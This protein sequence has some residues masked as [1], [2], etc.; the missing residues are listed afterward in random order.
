MHETTSANSQTVSCFCHHTRVNTLA[1][2]W[3]I[4]LFFSRL[5]FAHLCVLFRVLVCSYACL[6]VDEEMMAKVQRAMALLAFRPN[7]TCQPYRV[8]PRGIVGSLSTCI[9]FVAA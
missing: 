6:R 5:S 4:I 3:H 1:Y 7:T 9:W 8:C 2:N